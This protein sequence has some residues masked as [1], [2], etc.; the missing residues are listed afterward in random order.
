MAAL[1]ASQGSISSSLAAPSD[2]G[3][4]PGRRPEAAA[5]RRTGDGGGEA[6]PAP[7][8]HSLR[9]ASTSAGSEAAPSRGGAHDHPESAHLGRAQD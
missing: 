4:A 9:A 8:R 6:A 2:H 5:E 1:W 3:L 7:R